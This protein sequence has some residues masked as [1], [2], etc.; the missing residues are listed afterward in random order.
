MTKK[1]VADIIKKLEKKGIIEVKQQ[2]LNR[3]N[4]YSIKDFSGL[5]KSKTNEE[6]KAAI[7]TYEEYI[8]DSVLIETLQRK[9]YR[10]IKEKESSNT[11]P[12]KVTVVPDSNNHSYHNDTL[13]L[14]QSQE[15]ERYSDDDVKEIY[16]Y[17]MMIQ[18]NPLIKEDIDTLLFYIKEVLNCTKPTIRVCGENKPTM[19][20]IS[21]LMKL[22]YAE[23]LYVVDKFKE[24]T[25]KINNQEAYILTLLYKAKEQMNLDTTNQVTHD[26]YY[27]NDRFEK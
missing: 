24:Q 14:S 18:D 13:N 8:N 21:R 25:G 4:I 12:T 9:G 15:V 2:G 10:V 7:D 23:I 17:D 6:A 20:V 27:W 11:E 16:D 26:M 19:I 5:W 3:P 22:S 1:T